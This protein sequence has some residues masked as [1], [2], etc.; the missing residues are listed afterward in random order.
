MA[1][2][3]STSGGGLKT[4]ANWEGHAIS[5]NKKIFLKVK[6]FKLN[7]KNSHAI[8]GNKKFIVKKKVAT[9]QAIFCL[10][11]DIFKR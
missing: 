9:Y 8:S 6:S 5:G 1:S 11:K 10:I 4:A 3:T 7:D 2:G